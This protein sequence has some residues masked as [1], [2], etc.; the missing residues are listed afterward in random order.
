MPVYTPKTLEL[1]VDGKSID[2]KSSR[3]AAHK[4][5]IALGDP[6]KFKS[7]AADPKGFLTG[8]GVTI[9]D[10]IAAHL[11][12]RLAGVN[13]IEHLRAISDGNPVAATAWAIAAGAY[14]IASTKIAIAF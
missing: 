2:L 5:N 8:H 6:A 3:T 12:S 4:I 11:Q 7:F 9:A 10:D 1:A 13:S 14:S